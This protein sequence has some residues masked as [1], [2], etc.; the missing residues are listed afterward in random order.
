MTDTLTGALY[1]I[2]ADDRDTWVE[3]GM[4]LKSELGDGG[5]DL[6]DAW[7]QQSERYKAGDARSVWR[8]IKADG[9]IT[10]ATLY[11]EAKSRGWQGEAP[12]KQPPS[13]A[14][15]R[16][17]AASSARAKQKRRG[18]EA[19]AARRAEEM[20]AQ[21]TYVRPDDGQPLA[22]P[23]LMAKGFPQQPGLVLDDKLLVPMRHHLSDELQSVQMIDAD[24]N[25][26]FLPGGAASATVFRL[27]PPRA[28]AT[29]YCEGYATA[30]SIRAALGHLYRLDQV[31]CVFMASNLPKVTI[32]HG[33]VIADHDAHGVGQKYAE[34]TGLPWWM[35]EHEGWDANDVMLNE[36]VKALATALRE[37]MA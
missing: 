18:R 8:S 5:F 4:A 7:S 34:A 29:W 3:I 20:L 27:G 15:Q 26:L 9:G 32:R 19:A 16:R 21:A 11:H 1:S 25:K 17:R 12:V 28:Q 22:H 13:P 14:E 30:L 35:P 23:Y 33:Y 2:S 24:G 36:G 31:V 10:I 37:V 6:W